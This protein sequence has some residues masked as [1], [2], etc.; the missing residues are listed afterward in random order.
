MEIRVRS[1][2]GASSGSVSDASSRA[3]TSYVSDNCQQR[4]SGNIC[5]C[6]DFTYVDWSGES[7][8]GRLSIVQGNDGSAVLGRKLC[9]PSIIVLRG[10]HDEV[11]TVNGEQNRELA[12]LILVKWLGKEHAV[13]TVNLL[14]PHNLFLASRCLSSPFA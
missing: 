4:Y 7:I 12:R 14:F 11:S 9:V 2:C 3:S 1:M 6:A 8:L 13:G 10:S 5:I